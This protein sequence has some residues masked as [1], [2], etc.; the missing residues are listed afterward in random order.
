MGRH[1]SPRRG[2]QWLTALFVAV[3]VA[4]ALT[5][6]AFLAQAESKPL[7]AKSTP[8]AG[9]CSQTS[10]TLRV[11]TST[12]FAPVLA[13]VTPALA[14]GKDCIHLEVATVDGRPALG[15]LAGRQADVWIP[16]DSAW[17]MRAAGQSLAPAGQAGAGTVLATSPIYMVT[18]PAT[19]R[20]ITAAGASWAALSTLVAGNSGLTVV[21]R[22]PAGSGDGL[23]GAGSLADAIWLRKGMDSATVATL[24]RLRHTRTV[25]GPGPALPAR[26]GEVGLVP[27]YALLPLL[28]ST[29]KGLSVLSGADRTATLRFTWLPTAAAARDPGRRTKLARLLAALRDPSLDPTLRAAGLRRP[30]AGPPAGGA[31][32]A[33]LPA[34]NAQPFGVIEPHHV[35]HVFAAWYPAERREN[36]LIVVDVSGSMSAIAPGTNSSLIRLVAQGCLTVGGLLPEDS[37]VGLW[38]FGSNLD[39]PRD[40]K[41]LLPTAPLSTTQHAALTTA[42]SGLT[43][44]NTGTGLYDTLLAAYRSA[45][46]EYHPG[47]PNQVVLFTDG[48]NEDDPGSITLTQLVAG[49]RAATDPRRPVSIAV[50]AFG[51]QPQAGALAAALAPLKAKVLRVTSGGQVSAVFV[52]AAVGGLR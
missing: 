29:A 3:G 8:P 50:A 27:E 45:V 42:A 38:E 20:R 49:L 14:A 40:Y 32:I 41:V 35:D 9:A 13:A 52:H 16:D 10:A 6:V 30:G 11:T 5:L 51:T 4:I 7:A 2:I 34:L 36:V 25:T 18:D 44:L 19:A 28:D 46:A 39:K 21:V 33:R 23:V 47:T 12:S 31:G 17:A 43:A 24:A 15:Q 22:D 26:P 1:A 48:R 37:R